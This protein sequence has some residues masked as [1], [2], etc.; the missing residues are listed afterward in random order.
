MAEEYKPRRV[1]YSSR[2]Q[3]KQ[4]LNKWRR[5]WLNKAWRKQHLAKREKAA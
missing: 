2:L 4:A 5:N 1:E 3:Y